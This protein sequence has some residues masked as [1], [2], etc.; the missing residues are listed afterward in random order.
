[1]HDTVQKYLYQP[2]TFY[3]HTEDPTGVKANIIPI[4]EDLEIYWNKLTLFKPGFVNGDINLYFDLDVVIQNDITPLLHC[5]EDDLTL[6]RAYWKGDLVTDGSSDKF[7]ERWDMYANSS[8]MLWKN[9]MHHNIWHH[10]ENDM[11]YWMVKY[12]GMDR[13]LFH[14]G[15]KLNWFPKGLIYSKK[16][17]KPDPKALVCL[18]NGL[19]YH[20]TSS[21]KILHDELHS[22]K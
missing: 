10:F 2:F 12:K 6:V 3:C 18:F 13:F 11:D 1:M 8:V 5:L 17:E 9:G 20:H 16:W 7:K 14:E 4:E 15:F 19:Q 21:A 22:L